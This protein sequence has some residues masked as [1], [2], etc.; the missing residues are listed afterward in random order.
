MKKLF[1]VLLCLNIQFSLCTGGILAVASAATAPFVEAETQFIPM[2]IAPTDASSCLFQEMSSMATEEV[3]EKSSSCSSDDG[4]LEVIDVYAG[5]FV[6]EVVNTA[7][8]FEPALDDDLCKYYICRNCTA[9]QRGPPC[10]E[11][12]KENTHCLLKRE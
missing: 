10:F 6:L 1:A 9:S 5:G 3:P 7:I 12:A 11:G 4:C 8:L 2:S